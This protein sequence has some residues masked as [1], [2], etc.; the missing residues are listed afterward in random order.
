MSSEA[1]YHSLRIHKEAIENG[2]R[3]ANV[4]VTE[5]Y[6][7]C[8]LCTTRNEGCS[9]YM[10]LNIGYSFDSINCTKCWASCNVLLFHTTRINFFFIF[11]LESYSKRP[12]SKT[13]WVVLC[14]KCI[15]HNLNVFI[16]LLQIFKF[17][18]FSYAC[19]TPWRA[20]PST[21]IDFI[22]ILLSQNLFKP[23]KN[24]FSTTRWIIWC[25]K[26]IFHN[27]KHFCA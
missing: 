14:G 5:R 26:C 22:F 2:V 19:G 11:F 21:R 9:L 1:R 13:K 7:S 16:C 18:C 27:L 23:A 12:F 24:F 20:F 25:G 17:L 8:S 4:W 15:S 6:R 10:I 3:A